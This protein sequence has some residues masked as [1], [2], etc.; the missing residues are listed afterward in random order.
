M[1]AVLSRGF[2]TGRI[3]EKL[4]LEDSRARTAELFAAAGVI[5]PAFAPLFTR[6]G[7]ASLKMTEHITFI[8]PLFLV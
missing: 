6:I 2:Y 3:E 5:N 4:F 7:A 1:T 8:N